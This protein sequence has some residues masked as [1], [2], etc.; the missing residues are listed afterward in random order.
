LPNKETD[1]DMNREPKRL[2]PK[3]MAKEIWRPL[4]FDE[5]PA[6]PSA[7]PLGPL[8]LGDMEDA[9]EQWEAI[10]ARVN[11]EQAAQLEAD[12][13]Y[14]KNQTWSAAYGAAF[15][16]LGTDTVE[17]IRMVVYSRV[18]AS[19]MERCLQGELLARLG[20]S[21]ETFLAEVWVAI[22]IESGCGLVIPSQ[23][24]RFF[25]AA[26]KANLETV[27]QDHVAMMA[28]HQTKRQQQAA[29]PTTE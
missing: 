23:F 7:S 17:K 11:L 15:P 26:Y 21:V 25:E 14:H 13:A 2:T 12:R 8:V 4:V 24:E 22:D 29:E 6:E 19:L 16:V 10:V 9:K 3:E 18:A 5:P 27:E 1:V 28:E 20:A